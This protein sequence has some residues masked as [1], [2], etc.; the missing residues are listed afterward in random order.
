MP[1]FRFKRLDEAMIV[2]SLVAILL[3]VVF[4][5]PWSWDVT[6]YHLPFAARALGLSR[7]EQIT[8]L[9][10]SR[11][12][13][14]PVLWRYALAPGLIL[15]LPR[16]YVFPNLAAALAIAFSSVSALGKPWYAVLACT[17]CFPISLLGFSTPY[18]DYFTNVI[19]LAGAMHLFRWIYGA[20]S[21]YGSS[22]RWRLLLASLFLIIAANIKIQGLMIAVAISFVGFLYWI[23]LFFATKRRAVFVPVAR[24][25]SS[26]VGNVMFLV[27]AICI[28]VSVFLQPIN[29][30]LRFGNPLYPVRVFGLNGTE[31]RYSTPLEYLPQVPV[32]TSVISHFLSTTE[33]DPYL[34]S[35]GEAKPSL[36][37]SGD[38]NIIRKPSATNYSPRTGGTIG[39]IYIGLLIVALFGVVKTIRNKELLNHFSGQVSL[40]LFSLLVVIS[41]MPQSMELRYFLIAIYIP[42]LVAILVPSSES[43]EKV[44]KVLICSGLIIGILHI[45][46]YGRHILLPAIG[47][48]LNKELP[49]SQQCLA[50]GELSTNSDGR[51]MLTM[52]GKV[53]G[54]TVF[55]CR[56]VINPEVYIK[57][58]R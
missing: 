34:L 33:I 28:I 26:P 32:V 3:C 50:L 56:I 29:N 16:L 19:A 24:S 4:F 46:V 14:F 2:L 20:H 6:A 45:L 1:V 27:L 37:R 11:Y 53:L 39:P 21:F 15:D 40:V 17:L 42:A 10:T 35:G 44:A 49:S 8:P 36:L 25:K 57:Y 23:V 54:D 43:T 9:E 55:K 51:R 31:E 7:F 52:R 5:R 18:Q 12:D 41:A 38:M 47:L 48:N 30:L 58:E 13:G 22:D